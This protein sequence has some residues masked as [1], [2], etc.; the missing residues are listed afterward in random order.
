M[1]IN[2]EELF[3]SLI[4][5]SSSLEGD[6]G[7]YSNGFVYSKD[8]FFEDIHFKKEWLS[9]KQI[10]IKSSLVNISDAIA[11][12]AKPKYALLSIAMPKSI[13]K[14]QIKELTDGFL[15]MSKKYNYE[16]IGG[17][18]IANSKLDITMTF[19]SETKK[20]IFRKG[21]KKGDLVAFTGNLGTTSRD[22]KRLF[23]NKKIN[24]D[25]KFIT[26]I[27]RDKFMYKASRYINSALDIS[28]GL[29]KE[30]ERL[31]K[32]NKKGYKFFKNFDKNIGCSGEE[33][34]LLF[35]FSPK[36]LKYIQNIAKITKTPLTIFAEVIEGKYRSI[37]KEN[38]F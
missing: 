12:N 19:I 4:S 6:D 18:T 13:T 27:L 23:R 9:Y 37:C 1:K 8:A 35:T 36:N 30:L 38:H 20:P 14:N 31:S 16:I 28:D 34:E 26:P 11:M 21:M 3:I 24:K 7:A 22:L 15:E 29:F 32:L 25:S 33:Y 5:K 10:A 2:K 17:D